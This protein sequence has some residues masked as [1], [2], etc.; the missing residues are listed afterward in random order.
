MWPE[1]R[2]DGATIAAAMLF[3]AAAFFASAPFW[4]DWLI[5]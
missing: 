3:A 2:I 4:L 5:G 1:P